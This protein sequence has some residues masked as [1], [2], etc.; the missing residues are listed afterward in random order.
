MR[1]KLTHTAAFFMLLLT[2][3]L[4]GSPIFAQDKAVTGRVISGGIG[5]SGVSVQEKGTQHAVMTNADGVYTIKLSGPGAILVFSSVGYSSQELAADG[6]SSF[7]VTLVESDRVLSE[8]VVTALGI[9]RESKR[10]GYAI[11]EVKGAELV[12]ARDPNVFSQLEGKVAGLDIGT[13]PEL[14]GR[15]NIVLRGNK[16]LLIVVDGVPVSSD[17]WNV[18]ADD[19]ESVNVLKGPN[20]AALYGFRGQN[21][22]I[23][24][25][26]KRG[27]RTAKGWE[28]DFNSSNMLQKG[29]TVLPKDQTQFGRGTGYYYAYN[30]PKGAF[31]AG[32][33]LYDYG[34]RLAIWGPRM[35]GQ[36]VVQYNSPYDP[37]TGI[38]TP[39][40]YLTKGANNL[41]NFLEAGFLSTN[42]VS[43]A[44][45]GSN[46]DIR[47]S[48]SH[49]YQK[50]Q[51]PNT[52]INMDNLNL[53]AGYAI[54]SKLKAEASLNLNVQYT[55]NIP[56]ADYG[57]NSYVYMFN[58]Y[59]PADYD[60]R[61]LKNYYKGPQGVPGLN[62]Y[63]ENYGRSNNPYFMAHEWL[64]GKYKTDIYG[65]AKLTYNINKDFNLSFRTQITTWDQ[66]LTEK[67]PAG[68]IL[69]DYLSWYYPGWYGDY[70]ED[71]RNLMENNT[72]LLL[73]YKKSI[74]D[75]FITANVG[76]SER[77]YKYTSS[78]E[79]TR[80][81]AVPGV[82][83]FSNSQNPALAYNFGSNMQVY[84]GYYSL[85]V[86]Y[87][88]YV[89]L[90]TTGR[91]DN[92][93]TLPAANNTFFYPSVSL[94]TSI[95]DYVKLPKAINL[96]KVR[97]S[98]ADVKGGL[99][100]AQQGSAYYALTGNT[101]NGGL[102]GYGQEQFT[103]YDGPSYKN[104]SAYNVTTYYNGQPAVS[105]STNISDPALKP[106]DIKSYEA[107]LDYLM[108]K[109]RLGF[110]F[111][112]Y[113][114][115]NGPLIYPLPVASSTGFQ[116]HNVNAIVSKKKGEELV[117]NATP[118][119]SRNFSWDV[120][121]NWSTY[122]EYLHSVVGGENSVQLG[123][124]VFKIGD[125]LDADYSTAFVR[126]G[127]G[128]IVFSG[129]APLSPSPNNI[130]NYKLL[131][132]L[133]PNYSFGINNRFTY[134]SFSLSFQF[135]GRVGGKIYDDVWYHAMNGGTAAESDQGA[136]GIARNAEWE[137]TGQGSVAA[138]PKYVGQ[139]VT[140]ASGTPSYSGGVITNTKQIQFTPNTQAVTVQSYLSSGLGSNFDEFYTI[141]RTFAKL[142]EVR[143]TYNLSQKALGKKPIFR[144]ASVALI[145]RNLL[146]FA[147]RKDFDIDQYTSGFDIQTQS[148]TGTSSD[149]TLSSSTSRWFGFNLNLGF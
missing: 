51:A 39:T 4:A 8:V 90:S 105:Y 65:Y 128:N 77:S 103:A 112:Y 75:F 146:Y 118:V 16:D 141:S 61:D 124:H 30:N 67:V 133:D 104:Q 127:S 120:L 25:T 142:R 21:G 49:V 139:G 145:G 135:D 29:F 99:T 35:D 130:G 55:P 80:D 24:I 86:S 10:I 63:N 82:Y 37:A 129:G 41:K 123:N 53:T 59:G 20:A 83:S 1:P 143:L 138:V 62:Q 115:L 72:D 121:I 140:I 28:V 111:T 7:N 71:H 94:S 58:V 132:Y 137:T 56:D 70:R 98:F 54:S 13:S 15:P 92:L 46:Y 69:N 84:S 36:P 47:L 79:T 134:K 102:L 91:V 33:T 42:N 144:T 119:K 131:G 73:S 97:A 14:Y 96:L 64:R 81:L 108:F 60:V 93:S 38:W 122:R 31:L 40:P 22:A 26:T 74:S 88:N 27:S 114:N 109:G 126:D 76:T 117:F 101:L 44:S 87:K 100:Q 85:D 149:V 23:I 136:L 89:N 17:T 2:C 106:F 107:G 68:T 57:P 148:Q 147:Q 110:N 19:I 11:Q 43:M 34:Q 125:R 95:G 48:Y 9:R 32:E 45:S 5:I 18:N 50:G 3:L 116:T 113:Q 12:K 78:Y 66:L 6:Q 52:K